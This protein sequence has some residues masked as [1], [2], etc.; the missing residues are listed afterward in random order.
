MVRSNEPSFGTRLKW[1]M[2]NCLV[3]KSSD[4]LSKPDTFSILNVDIDQ[5]RRRNIPLPES[6]NSLQKA[7]AANEESSMLSILKSTNY[8]INKV[9]PKNAMNALYF[10]AALDYE[11]AV[12]I[13]LAHG[14][15]VN[16]V[17]D[18][19]RTPLLIVNGH[20]LIIRR[21]SWEIIVS[22]Q[23]SFNQILI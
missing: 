15:K 10:A 8:D 16:M 6:Y 23:S 7:I 20:S 2:S 18:R 9:N 22:F 11:K 3:T 4:M 12:S 14:A 5:E 13:L 19:G 17:V 1:K 21:L